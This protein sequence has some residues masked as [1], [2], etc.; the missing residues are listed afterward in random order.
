MHLVLGKEIHTLSSKAKGIL[1]HLA[2]GKELSGISP[3]EVYWRQSKK[4]T[5]MHLGLENKLQAE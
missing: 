2:L 5:S 4:E 3:K 1:M